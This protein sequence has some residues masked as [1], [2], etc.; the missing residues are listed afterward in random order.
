MELTDNVPTR[1]LAALTAI[2][3][4]VAEAVRQRWTAHRSANEPLLV[5]FGPHNSGKTS[6]LH[7][8]L[9]DDELPVPP[10]LRVGARP[11]ETSGEVV[12]WRGWRVLDVPGL[13]SEQKDHDALAWE[14]VELADAIVL[15]MSLKLLTGT[16]L[17]VMTLLDGSWW[18]GETASP[19]WPDGALHV[20]VARV[21]AGRADPADDPDELEELKDDLEEQLAQLLAGAHPRPPVDWVAAS[22]NGI[23]RSGHAPEATLAASRLWDGMAE[24]EDRLGAGPGDVTGLRAA[25]LVRYL[26]RT[27]RAVEDELSTQLAQLEE[28]MHA[29]RTVEAYEQTIDR[30]VDAALAATDAKVRA[31][32]QESFAA[33]VDSNDPAPEVAMHAELARRADVVEQEFRRDLGA[34][35]DGLQQVLEA[36]PDVTPGPAQRWTA[37][38]RQQAKVGKPIPWSKASNNVNTLVREGVELKLNDSITATKRKLKTLEGKRDEALAKALQNAGFGSAA[39]AETARDLLKKYDHAIK[40]LGTVPQ[41]VELVQLG[42]DVKRGRD[43]RRRAKGLQAR[44]EELVGRLAEALLTGPR[45][46]RARLERVRSAAEESLP[47]A[48]NLTQLKAATAELQGWQDELRSALAELR[49][50]G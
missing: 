24:L 39:D 18:T 7:R 46:F 45:G 21:D 34:L 40:A 22:P 29:A 1:V 25:T 14:G 43:A 16:G 10:W 19:P 20:V 2:D 31:V 38:R 5:L 42:R 41:L 8:L 30:Q 12:T 44:E 17:E 36:M 15:V 9:I 23:L 50:A 27:G 3:E 11:E 6:L 48:E 28:R 37:P 47:G 33:V 32:V 4:S 26:H 35:V 49:A 13:G